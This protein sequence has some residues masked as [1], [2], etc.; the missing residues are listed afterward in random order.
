MRPCGPNAATRHHGPNTVAAQAYL[1]QKLLNAGYPAPEEGAALARTRSEDAPHTDVFAISDTEAAKEVSAPVRN[2]TVRILNSQARLGID[3]IQPEAKAP[4][5]S[6]SDG[7]AEADKAAS[8]S[9]SA[10]QDM[11]RYKAGRLSK[12]GLLVATA[13]R[14]VAS[15]AS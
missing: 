4:S 11:L 5:R 1:Q 15:R 2:D 6:D 13:K 10:R 14:R 3:Q 7:E 8:I 12:H 9:R